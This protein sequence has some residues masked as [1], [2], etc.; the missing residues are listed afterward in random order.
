MKQRIYIFLGVF[1]YGFFVLQWG[2]SPSE[3]L[4]KF[5]WA[6]QI[7]YFLDNDP[8]LLNFY[9][10]YGHP[11][12]TL[13]GLGSLLC[14][15]L[16]ISYAQALVLSMSILVAGATAACAVVCARL[17]P[18]SLW[19]IAVTFTLLFSRL[20]IYSTP[21]TAVVL[22][23]LVLIVLSTWRLCEQ[24]S[25]RTISSYVLW[26]VAVG[27]STATRVDATL[28]V[29]FPMF[30]V[31]WWQLGNRVLLPTISA[32]VLSFF[33]ADPFLWYM[34]AQHLADLVHKFS[35]H[36]KEFLSPSK[37]RPDEW[38][39][40]IPLALLSIGWALV[41]LFKRR[42]P[43][44]MPVKIMLTLMGVSLL[45]AIVILSSSYQSIRYFYP[46]IIIWEVLLPLFMLETFSSAGLRTDS[47]IR[48]QVDLFQWVI[49]GTVV[50]IQL[51][52]YLIV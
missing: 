11:G 28:L 45:S 44:L 22:P 14:L 1:A 39:H 26:G 35:I 51:F 20:H 32:T 37:I 30:M 33:A 27:L 42:Q 3:T 23:F 41:H 10:A 43:Q 15:S 25:A 49:L 2:V 46:V 31:V 52:A 13:V 5:M 40:A 48:S 36:Y 24:P 16:G 9:A 21:P 29:S 47:V 18:H 38:M 6:N 4:D 12:T 8:R 17:Y 7:Q 34:P 50:M 19:W